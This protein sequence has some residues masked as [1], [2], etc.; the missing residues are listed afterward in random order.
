V[1]T[2]L[3]AG[4]GNA[5][6]A[7]FLALL[8][9]GLGGLFRRSPA[10]RHLLWVL[11]LLKLITPPLG[12]IPVA[13]PLAAPE[14]EPARPV[15]REGGEDADVLVEG[16]EVI[17]VV[18]ATIPKIE[19]AP[20]PFP[21]ALTW[22]QAVALFWL[23]GS[24]VTFA[25]AAVRVQ[26]FSRILRLA[27]PFSDEANRQ[28]EA[29]ARRLG[30]GRVPRLWSVP[31]AVSPMLWSLGGP[32]RLIV[33]EELWKSCDDRQRATLLAHELAHL[34]RRDHWVRGLELLVTGLY[35]W[36]PTVWLA[37]RALR[38]AE[39]HCCDAWVVWALPDAARTYAETLLQTVDFLSGAGSSVPVGASGLGHLHHLKR[40]LIMI[41][42]GTTS[43]TFG[44][45]G[46]LLV[47]SLSAALLP[48]SPAWAQRPES[49]RKDGPAV[50]LDKDEARR[51]A[52]EKQQAEERLEW[53]DR[54]YAK[55]Y[56]SKAQN[57]A[58]RAA[59][60]RYYS[61]LQEAQTKDPAGKDAD[62]AS[63]VKTARPEELAKI[64]DELRERL[65]D[66]QNQVS[67]DDR[68]ARQDEAKRLAQK[69]EALVKAQADRKRANEKVEGDTAEKEKGELEKAKAEMAK[70]QAEIKELAAKVQEKH[71]E[72]QEAERALQQAIGRLSKLANSRWQRDIVI[73]SRDGRVFEYR[74]VRPSPVRAPKVP[75][76]PRKP[77]EPDAPTPRARV[78]PSPSPNQD[79]RIDALEKRLEQLLDEIKSLKKEREEAPAPKKEQAERG[80]IPRPFAGYLSR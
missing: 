66:L 34:R 35:W 53:S 59:L 52:A 50:S 36:L 14:R 4:L 46:G 68:E 74:V 54:M 29:L 18:Q 24:V 9:A 42:Q 79:A 65:R 48:L 16:L 12:E 33:P 43:R 73:G 13:W 10:L 21:I 40:R 72:F 58:D 32:P 26:R 11:V 3:Q 1:Q 61:A 77:G 70:A 71:R 23:A 22:W 69:L 25:V 75:D 78:A 28:V 41:M 38:E 64:I 20:N 57:S 2:L 19:P 15:A 62:E 5:V 7:T 44:W 30:L 76:S 37:R 80:E 67:G 55:G 60:V 6:A 17:D 8:V 45:T 51:E 31:G 39:E 49:D 56:V 27:Q 47:L 63:N